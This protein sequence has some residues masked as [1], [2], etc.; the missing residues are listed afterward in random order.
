[1]D[2]TT[3]LLWIA[4]ILW[5]VA[6]APAKWAL[7]SF[8]PF[9]LMFLRLLF[10]GLLFLPYALKKRQKKNVPIPWKRLSILSFTGVAGYSMLYT[11][12]I[13]LTSGTHVS[14]IDASIPLFIL[15]LSAFYLKEK[16]MYIQWI[17]LAIGTLGVLFISLPITNI[18]ITSEAS[19][20]NG[21]SFVGDMLIL[22][23]AWLFAFYTIQLKRP[24]AEAAL[25]SE[26]FTALTLILGALVVCPFALVEMF[27]YGWSVE[28]TVKSWWSLCFLVLGSSILA[29]WCWN[30]ALEKV[31][32]A[33]SGIYLNILPLVSIL[34]SV[35]FLHE[36][37]TGKI[38][39]GGIFV[40]IGVVMAEKASRTQHRK[41][42]YNAVI[43][44][45]AQEKEVKEKETTA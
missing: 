30:T 42:V 26:M 35:V 43:E 24:Q 22:A 33:R 39:L 8:P 10:A 5:G 41:G 31:S 1:M 9:F 12:G 7:E 20:V 14:I 38:I 45:A 28:V 17:A 36:K 23:S 4:I 37:L 11:F 29:Y 16:I 19:D 18:A 21:S 2:K 6:I 3:A 34:A 44:K 15:L 27:L 13:A 32:G 25:S 40:L